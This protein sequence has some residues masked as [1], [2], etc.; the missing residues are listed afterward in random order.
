[1][2]RRETEALS[3]QQKQVRGG[4]GRKPEAGGHLVRGRVGAFRV[5]GG[6]RSPL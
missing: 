1:M 5:R 6:Q 3:T 4:G 2:S